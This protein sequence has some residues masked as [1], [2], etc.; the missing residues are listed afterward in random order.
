MHYY[1]FIW[2]LAKIIVLSFWYKG[3]I[4]INY[5]TISEWME[6]FLFYLLLAFDFIF[7]IMLLSKYGLIF[8][9]HS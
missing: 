3:K 5:F 4:K 9:V 2:A 1:V 7:Y 8:Y 6:R